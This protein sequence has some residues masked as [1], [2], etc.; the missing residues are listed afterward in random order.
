MGAHAFKEMA[1]NFNRLP[2]GNNIH[3][4]NAIDEITIICT[5]QYGFFPGSNL[6]A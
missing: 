4:V 6:A 3:R 1:E 5:I 2:E